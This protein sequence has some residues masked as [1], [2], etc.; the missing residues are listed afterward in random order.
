MIIS[1]KKNRQQVKISGLKRPDHQSS[2]L[3]FHRNEPMHCPVESSF[4]LFVYPGEENRSAVLHA[5]PP[6]QAKTRIIVK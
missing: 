6:K 3:L 4:Q 5:L 1:L 2:Q